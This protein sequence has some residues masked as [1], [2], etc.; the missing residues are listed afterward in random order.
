MGALSVKSSES[1][2]IE[3]LYCCAAELIVI[4]TEVAADAISPEDLRLPLRDSQRKPE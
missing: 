2:G 1:I 4:L 3:D